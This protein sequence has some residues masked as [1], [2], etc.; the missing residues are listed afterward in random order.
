MTC[1]NG[2]LETMA[3]TGKLLGAEINVWLQES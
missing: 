3:V 1:F 2:P